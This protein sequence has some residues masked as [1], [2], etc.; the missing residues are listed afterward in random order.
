[1][2]RSLIL[3]KITNVS[4]AIGKSSLRSRSAF[5]GLLRSRSFSSSRLRPPAVT[6]DRV[7]CK[8]DIGADVVAIR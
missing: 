5:S 3:H 7:W 6:A 4:L 8:L 1:M 2:K